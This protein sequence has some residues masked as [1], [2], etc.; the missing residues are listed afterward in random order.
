MAARRRATPPNSSAK[1]DR[2]GDDPDVQAGNRENVRQ[3]GRG[4][5]VA[6]FRRQLA[7]IGD[8]QRADERRVVPKGTI[9]RP[10]RRRSPSPQ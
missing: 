7:P 2:D 10:A 1:L 3:P 6:Q 4:K 5:S 8:E 9:D